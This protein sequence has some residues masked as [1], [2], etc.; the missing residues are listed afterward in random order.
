MS[1]PDKPN[2]IETMRMR[3]DG[4][5]DRLPLHLSRLEQSAAAFEIPFRRDRI[6]AAIAEL[7]AEGS[8]RRI[9][10]ELSAA[11][12]VE[13]NSYPCPP[14]D[15][16]KPWRLAIAA[17]RLQ[18]SDPMLRH[19]T[20]KRD[21]YI[22]ARGE[23]HPAEADEVLLLNENGA[24]CE[25]TISNIFIK[26]PHEAALRTPALECGLLKGVL[27]QELIE[28]GKAVEAVLKINDLRSAE[29]LYVGN[30]LR[31]LLP[32]ILIE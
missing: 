8:D 3:A 12:N 10:L 21:H 28:A 11:G 32:A 1:S 4:V 24:V 22:R 25:G 27:R 15:P 29:R 7:E 26:V 17:T 23:Y 14:T 18:S 6:E 2:L 19:K 5:L 31:G 16:D 9:R 20:T 13:I 30:S